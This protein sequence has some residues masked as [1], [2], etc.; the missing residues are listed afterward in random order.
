MADQ[1]QSN[2]RPWWAPDLQTT[3]ALAIV[4][5][6][7]TSLFYR[8]THPSAVEDKQLDTMLTIVFSTA[9][10]ALVNFLF[11]SSRSS[12]T[13]DDTL[14]RLAEMP[15]VIAPAPVPPAPAPVAPEPTVEPPKP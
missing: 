8:M 5:I 9:F 10:V 12:Q 3:V 2:S 6:V 13:K 4:V 14:G 11:G 15:A 1:Q 7:G